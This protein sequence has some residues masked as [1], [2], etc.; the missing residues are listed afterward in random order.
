MEIHHII[1]REIINT[2]TNSSLQEELNNNDFLIELPNS[3]REA[4]SKKFY[5]YHEGSHP[6]YTKQIKKLLDYNYD[7]KLVYY[8]NFADK[9][10]NCINCLAKKYSEA[11]SI[12]DIFLDLSYNSDS[13]YSDK[14]IHASD[15]D[16]F[17]D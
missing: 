8:K 7:R 16:V 13:D 12:N 15:S 14:S 2:I 5:I 11:T 3:K 4:N 1:P 9:I 17:L 6:N 10:R